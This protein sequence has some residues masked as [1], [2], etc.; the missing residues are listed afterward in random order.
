MVVVAVV[1]VVVVV[2][3]VLDGN[4]RSILVTVESRFSFAVVQESGIVGSEV[5]VAVN[6]AAV[7]RLHNSPGLHQ[8]QLGSLVVCCDPMRSVAIVVLW[9]SASCVVVVC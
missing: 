5:E 4:R 8:M 2:V 7:D 1:V 9:S 3:V 6:F